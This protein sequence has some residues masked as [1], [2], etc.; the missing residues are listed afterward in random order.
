MAINFIIN[1]DGSMKFRLEFK[2]WPLVLK[3][4]T[5]LFGGISVLWFFGIFIQFI[6]AATTRNYSM[7][8]E[9]G[10]ISLTVF[11][12]T[13]IGGIFESK[14]D[15][16]K[17]VKKLYDSSLSFLITAISFFFVYSMSSALNIPSESLN[18]VNSTLIVGSIFIA[19]L[20]SFT[21][22]VNGLLNL[23]LILVNHRIAI[24]KK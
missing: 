21:G 4:T 19:M 23:F 14:N 20:I 22:I 16:S 10:Q 12:F 11:G 2:K 1:C 18:D 9:Y 5:L 6:N 15:H 3:I 13:L 8:Y 17:I 24:D 7:F